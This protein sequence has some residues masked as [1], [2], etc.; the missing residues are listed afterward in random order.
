M[1]S[2]YSRFDFKVIKDFANSPNF[3]ETR[4]R[5]HYELVKSKADQKK[6]IGLQCLQT[7]P[8]RVTFIHDDRIN[9]NVHKNVFRNLHDVLTSENW[10]PNKYIEAEIK[11][12][13][14]KTRGQLTSDEMENEIRHYV[15]SL[16]HNPQW[17][18][19]ITNDINKLPVDREYI[20]FF[21]QIYM[22]W[23]KDNGLNFIQ[24]KIDH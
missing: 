6:T 24:P 22:Q 2:F 3:E 13:L 7:I 19:R 21:M 14:D 5:F 23:S 17:V 1:K 16:N 15:E 4:K 11:K 18:R 10:F 12:K 8:Q 20:D 9:L